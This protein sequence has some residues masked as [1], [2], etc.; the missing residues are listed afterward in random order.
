M[1]RAEVNAVSKVRLNSVCGLFY[2]SICLLVFFVFGLLLYMNPA[3]KNTRH[4]R[5]KRTAFALGGC[6]EKK[7][8]G[9]RSVNR[10]VRRTEVG[11]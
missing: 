1:R 9:L 2:S 4:R 5:S 7:R 6:G 10:G 3:E 8:L 11:R